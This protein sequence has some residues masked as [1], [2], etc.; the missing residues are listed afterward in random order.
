MSKR[1]ELGQ[2][3]PLHPIFEY[4][5]QTYQRILTVE[6]GIKLHHTN[7]PQKRRLAWECFVTYAFL[8]SSLATYWKGFYLWEGYYTDKP[9]SEEQKADDKAKAKELFKIAADK[10]NTDAQFYYAISL[11][12]SKDSKPDLTKYLKIAA[13]NRN[14]AAQYNLACL[15]LKS[16][17]SSSQDKEIGLEY[18]NLAI[19]NNNDKA[20]ELKKSLNLDIENS[21]DE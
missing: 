19:Q 18:L 16:K 15:Y 1:I 20:L 5:S 14:G 9:I 21:N 13:D 6:E 12:K 8:S 7:D 10:G 11:P 17:T 3:P 4:S 2:S